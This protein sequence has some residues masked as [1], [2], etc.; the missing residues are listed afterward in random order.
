ML[1]PQNDSPSRIFPKANYTK[2]C[3]TFSHVKDLSDSEDDDLMP[4]SL[5]KS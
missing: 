2:L 4:W 5:K 1:N 3:N